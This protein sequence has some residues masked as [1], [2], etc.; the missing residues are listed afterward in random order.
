MHIYV[1]G[2]TAKHGAAGSRCREVQRLHPAAKTHTHE[3]DPKCCNSQCNLTLP[4]AG[5]QVWYVQHRTKK[6]CADKTQCCPVAASSPASQSS[7]ARSARRIPALS[8][9][10]TA[11]SAGMGSLLPC[12]NRT[13][14][15]F[16][17]HIDPP[18][19]LPIPEIVLHLCYCLSG[20]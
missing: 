15:H 13:D 4:M 9:T 18:S 17:A 16:C 20:Q 3:S 12:M 11:N 7:K 10:A 8:T 19:S 1:H 5:T 6:T 2:K 14:L